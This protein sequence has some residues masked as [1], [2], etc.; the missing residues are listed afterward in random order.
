MASE[1]GAHIMPREPVK[2]VDKEGPID[3]AVAVH[4]DPDMTAPVLIEGVRNAADLFQ[5]CPATGTIDFDELMD[6][7]SIASLLAEDPY[8]KDGI[9]K[10][11]SGNMPLGDTGTDSYAVNDAA[12]VDDPAELIWRSPVMA[13]LQAK[14][15]A[16]THYLNDAGAVD[17]RG[18]LSDEERRVVTARARDLS[19]KLKRIALQEITSANEAA[20][21]Q[22][23][24]AVRESRKR[25]GKY[26]VTK[27]EDIDA[28]GLTSAELQTL[29]GTEV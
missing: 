21:E 1:F 24:A 12:W 11:P 26:V 13:Q 7:A 14:L 10:D 16:V 8:V 20:Q 18:S 28:G 5:R 4:I 23:Q 3:H 27:K 19:N 22:A 25:F 15:L 2:P 9:H 29:Y 6:D 17:F